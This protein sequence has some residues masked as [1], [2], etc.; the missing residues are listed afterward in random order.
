MEIKV[1]LVGKKVHENNENWE[2]TKI[3]K[4]WMKK[5]EKK[6]WFVR[7]RDELTVKNATLLSFRPRPLHKKAAAQV[8]K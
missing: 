1:H 5:N 3:D 4:W 6:K 8:P 2:I 7:L